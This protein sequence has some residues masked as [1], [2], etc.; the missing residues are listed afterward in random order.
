MICLLET[1][2]DSIDYS[3]QDYLTINLHAFDERNNTEKRSNRALKKSKQKKSKSNYL[4]D[5]IIVNTLNNTYSYLI[6]F[7]LLILSFTTLLLV[8]HSFYFF[9]PC[10]KLIFILQNRD[11]LISNSSLKTLMSLWASIANY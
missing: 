2:R 8:T 9:H 6:I 1:A 10:Q 5:R 4:N 7:F 3:T 11:T